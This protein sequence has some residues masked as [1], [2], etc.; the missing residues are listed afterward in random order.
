MKKKDTIPRPD[1]LYYSSSVI[2]PEISPKVSD[3]IHG[4]MPNIGVIKINPDNTMKDTQSFKETENILNSFKNSLKNLK[5]TDLRTNETAL[6]RAVDKL[7]TVVGFMLK[8][9]LEVPKI[10]TDFLFSV[11]P[12][13]KVSTEVDI[14]TNP[15]LYKLSG[16]NENGEVKI[17]TSTPIVFK[18]GTTEISLTCEQLTDTFVKSQ[19]INGQMVEEMRNWIKLNI[20]RAGTLEKISD[21]E[22]TVFQKKLME[23][24]LKDNNQEQP[25]TKLEN[26]EHTV[27]IEV[28]PSNNKNAYELRFSILQ[29]AVN[30]LKTNTN[31]KIS[32]NDVLDVANKFYKFVENKK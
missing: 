9:G 20:H 8:S 19:K 17:E 12:P 11:R 3:K 13:K 10:Y 21:E 29:E 26:K 7:D 25:N 23:K 2:T 15:P 16:V 5:D 32:E 28:P 4:M 1:I 14:L 6:E 27:K 22:W 24:Y 30:L 18:K 31:G